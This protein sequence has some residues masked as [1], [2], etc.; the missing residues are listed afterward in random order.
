M[1]V[2]ITR[3]F[4]TLLAPSFSPL[5]VSAALELNGGAISISRHVGYQSHS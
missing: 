1:E 2:I 3:S 5:P 4:Q